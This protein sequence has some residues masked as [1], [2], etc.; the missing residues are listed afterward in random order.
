MNPDLVAIWLVTFVTLLAGA[1]IYSGLRFC[2]L[3][4]YSLFYKGP[5]DD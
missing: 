2:A 5:T 1:I 3:E 4:I